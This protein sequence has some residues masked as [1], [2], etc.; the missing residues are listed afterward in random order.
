M[1]RLGYLVLA[2]GAAVASADILKL[3]LKRIDKKPLTLS[4]RLQLFWDHFTHPRTWKLLGDSAPISIHDFS[5]A[6]YYGEVNIGSPSQT[7][8]VIYDTGSS[9][10]WVPTTSCKE[11][12]GGKHLYDSSKSSSYV[13]NGTAFNIAYGSGP[14][15][16]YL[17][18]D[19]VHLGDNQQLALDKYEFAEINEVSGLGMAYKMGQFDGILGLG[20]DSISVD[21]I[22]TVLTELIKNNVISKPIFSFFLGTDT[23]KDGELLVGDVDTRKFKGD[24]SYVPVSQ[25]GYWEVD[26]DG[27]KLGGE[28][29][30]GKT[31]AIVDS[32]TSVIAAPPDSVSALA[33]KIGAYNI[34]GKYIVSCTAD[35]GDIEFTLGGKDYKID[36]SKLLIPVAFGHCFL[37]VIPLSVPPPRGPL[38]ILGDTFMREYYTVFDYGQKRVGLA[39][40]APSEATD[41]NEKRM[42]ALLAKSKKKKTQAEAKAD[43]GTIAQETI[44]A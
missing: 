10:L 8:E 27:V 18:Y 42:E 26:M 32:G 22:P 4:Q 20:W 35:I 3:D 37:A 23:G 7:F 13:K 38:W 33:Q 2:T 40:A 44:Y 5:N 12:G 30:E 34:F 19:A 43:E 1:T 25:E 16:G 15:A 28:Q 31:K 24:I 9:N 6:Q 11:C 39:V 36:G 41:D 14:V 17:S 21:G 29:L